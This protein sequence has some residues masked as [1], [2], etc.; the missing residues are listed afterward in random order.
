[1]KATVLIAG[2][3]LLLC[4]SGVSAEDPT[5]SIDVATVP[6]TAPSPKRSIMLYLRGSEGYQLR[7]EPIIIMEREVPQYRAGIRACDTL[8]QICRPRED[9]SFLNPGKPEE[10]KQYCGPLEPASPATCTIPPKGSFQ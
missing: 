6:T 8:M 9:G 3:A 1:M 7:N 2:I 4:G 10:Q 5:K